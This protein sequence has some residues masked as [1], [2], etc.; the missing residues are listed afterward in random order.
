MTKFVLSNKADKDLADIFEYGI[1]NF[2]VERATEYL[3]GINEKFQYISENKELGRSAEEISKGLKR[4]TYN[5]H[6]VFFKEQQ[7]AVLIVRVLRR[8]MDFD[9]HLY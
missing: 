4:I 9:R 3:L 5:K 1:L 2:G 7:D 8:E 6:V